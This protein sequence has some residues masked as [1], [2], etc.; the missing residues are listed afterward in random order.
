MPAVPDPQTLGTLSFF[1]GLAPEQLQTLNTLLHRKTFP[2]GATLMT[3][4][5]PGEV[6]YLIVSGTVKVHVEQADG[7]D[8][9]LAI[10]GPGELLGE[11]SLIQQQGRSANVVT[12]ES[13][14]LFWLDRLAFEHSLDTLPQLARNLNRILARRLRL[15]NAQI[16]SLATKDIFGRVA[17]L[18]L[19]F[20]DT[21]GRP[22]TDGAIE[23]PLRLTQSDLASLVGASRVR[24]NQVLGFYKERSY[25]AIQPDYHLIIH[26]RT[27]LTRRCQ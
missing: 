1:Q 24:V 15:A 10:L 3:A 23:V 16:Q 27:A 14:T 8:V 25:L 21:Y 13:S 12:L 5:Q 4:E 2:A 9:I 18:V 6:A 19:A 22:T 11:L 20:A 17:C 7:S 26:D